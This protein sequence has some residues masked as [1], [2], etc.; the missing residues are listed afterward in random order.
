[1]GIEGTAGLC[2]CVALDEG[3]REPGLSPGGLHPSF[4][5]FK[6]DLDSGAG[7][8]QAGV[9]AGLQDAGEPG[10]GVSCGDHRKVSGYS[11]GR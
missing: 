2:S 10:S 6:P 1:M 8:V 9:W 4:L 5:F 11:G 3:L 7:M